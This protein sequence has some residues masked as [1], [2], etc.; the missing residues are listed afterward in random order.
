MYT[1]IKSTCS[2]INIYPIIEYKATSQP[3]IVY[4]K[5]TAIVPYSYVYYACVF[6]ALGWKY[7]RLIDKIVTDSKQ[8]LS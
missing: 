5:K 7:K 2:V 1:T 8:A 6:I 3:A 4:R